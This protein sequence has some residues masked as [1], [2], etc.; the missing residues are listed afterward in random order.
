MS[1]SQSPECV[2][3]L[4]LH[5]KK[6]FQDVIK[7]WGGKIILGWSSGLNVIRVSL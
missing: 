6:D 4:F 2:I 5:G 7:L 3:V 1:M